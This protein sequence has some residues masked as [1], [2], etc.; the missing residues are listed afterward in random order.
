MLPIGE[1]E[2]VPDLTREKKNHTLTLLRSMVRQNLT[3]E[4]V[5]KEKEICASFAVVP[6]TAEVT[7]TVCD[8]YLVKMEKALNLWVEDMNRKNVQ[9]YQWFQ[10]STGVL[11][12]IR[13]G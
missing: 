13:H 1:K 5:K 10:A 3:C 12:R 4:I 2:K 8:K 11:E 7:A 9:Y 6:Q